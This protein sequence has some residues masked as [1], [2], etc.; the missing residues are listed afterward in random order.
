MKYLGYVISSKGVAID[1]GK[2]VIMQEWPK[3]KTVKA[4]SGF[5]GIDFE[6]N[7]F[8]GL[9]RYYSK[10]IQNYGEIAAPLT[11]ILKGSLK[12]PKGRRSF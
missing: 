11:Q 9:T 6:K 1:S 2:I 4:L 8:L 10:F 12:Y 5:L 7:G 3:P